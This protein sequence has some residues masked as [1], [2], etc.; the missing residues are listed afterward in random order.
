[1]AAG[2][3][4]G[5]VFV[6]GFLVLGAFATGYAQL[7][8]AISALE[9]TDLGLAQQANFI[10]F[11]ILQICFALGLRREMRE[12][13]GSNLAPLL[14]A[15]SGLAVIGDGLFIHAPLHLACDLVA[16]NAAIIVLCLFAWRFWRDRRWKGWSAYSIITALLMMAFLTAFGFANVHGGPAGAFEKLA[17]ASRTTWTVLLVVRLLSGRRL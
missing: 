8:E 14:Q 4:G 5:L 13:R 2:A 9:F 1:M 11:G 16:F 10:L 12:G 7:H 6:A 15:L 3:V 17:V